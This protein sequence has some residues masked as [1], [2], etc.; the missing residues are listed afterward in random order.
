MS[1][2]LNE[3]KWEDYEA[4]IISM[5]ERRCM[6]FY[7]D[8]LNELPRFIKM[9][10]NNIPLEYNI[11]KR[12]D[13]MKTVMMNLM[14]EKDYQKWELKVREIN[15]DTKLKLIDEFLSDPIK[16]FTTN[17]TNLAELWMFAHDN[18][19]ARIV[20]SLEFLPK[21]L[22]N[23]DKYV[24]DESIKSN[25]MEGLIRELKYVSSRDIQRENDLLSDSM[26]ITCE[27]MGVTKDQIHI[28]TSDFMQGFCT[29]RISKPCI[30]MRER[31]KAS[32][33]FKNGEKYEFEVHFYS[34]VDTKVKSR[35]QCKLSSAIVVVDMAHKGYVYKSLA[36][37]LAWL[38][39]R[40]MVGSTINRDNYC[41]SDDY[42]MEELHDII[43]DPRN[44]VTC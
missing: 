19:C 34:P 18:A 24:A 3:K 38:E 44:S 16:Y 17:G 27:R 29:K 23:V 33:K 35:N 10:M 32:K 9:V 26:K 30:K 42:L 22:S 14:D 4:R 7:G 11:T 2:I 37:K 31:T 15:S 6:T 36:Q 5:D 12:F 8:T 1:Q 41:A 20:A 43:R 21:D 39:F 13:V 40:I 28:I 25:S